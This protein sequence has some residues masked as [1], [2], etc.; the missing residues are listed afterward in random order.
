[1]RRVSK[2]DAEPRRVVWRLVEA[3]QAVRPFGPAAAVPPYERPRPQRSRRMFAMP[4][5]RL[6]TPGFPGAGVH[7]R[8]EHGRSITA[9]GAP[10]VRA[11][12]AARVA[13]KEFRKILR[14]AVTVRRA[15]PL[16]SDAGAEARYY[17]IT[18]LRTAAAR[19][20]I[21]CVE[22]IGRRR[23]VKVV[24]TGGTRYWSSGRGPQMLLPNPT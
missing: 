12:M 2:D 6:E 21:P 16:R 11:A 20:P 14:G 18:E 8:R 5:M 24:S 9:C 15:G 7:R 4:G 17:A 3:G 19:S 22:A 23:I 10:T 1:M 13:P